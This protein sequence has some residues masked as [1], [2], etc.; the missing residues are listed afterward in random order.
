MLYHLVSQFYFDGQP[1]GEPYA[2]ASL[3][4]EGFIHLSATPTQ[5]TW[6]ANA[7]YAAVPDLVVLV[8]DENLLAAP[9]QWD[10]TPDGRFPHLYGPLDREAIVAMLALDRGHDG[11]LVYL[12]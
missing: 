6:V 5:V 11:R 9:V 4:E 10:E 2:P 8:I 12:G 7:F 1:A 3:F